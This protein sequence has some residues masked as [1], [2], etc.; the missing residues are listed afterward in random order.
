MRMLL[1]T[2]AGTAI[3]ALGATSAPAETRTS[4]GVRIHSG[5]GHA[6]PGFDRLERRDRR[7]SRGA[8][9]VIGDFGGGEWALYNNRAFEPDSYNDWWHE[10]PWRSYPRWITAGGC[11][12]L[13]WGG[14]E[15][16][17]SWQGGSA[18][19]LTGGR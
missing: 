18:P 2:M 1:A 16:R 11:D 17:C 9:V 12:R 15:W 3:M 5:S 8:D 19:P 13:W 14:G 7:R 10:R 4:N 6:Q